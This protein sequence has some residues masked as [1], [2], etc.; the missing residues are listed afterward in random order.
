MGNS[1]PARERGSR[2]ARRRCRGCGSVTPT[3]F[4]LRTVD[5]AGNSVPFSER[6][7]AAARSPTLTSEAQRYLR[8]EPVPSPAVLRRHLDTEG[9]S[10]EHLAI[11]SNLDVSAEDYAVSAARSSRRSSDAGAAH[12]YAEDSQRHLAPPK[13]SE[14][15]AEQD[16]RLEAAFGG[17]A[18][19]MTAALRTALREEGTFLDEEIVDL[20]TGQKTI[21]QSPIALLPASATLPGGAGCR[22][23]AGRLR[24]PPGRRTVLLPYLP[25]PL[26]IGVSI[27]GYDFTGAEVFHER[28][29]VRR[30]TGRS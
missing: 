2:A 14:Q 18:A 29:N 3:A 22:T 6:E 15:M 8:F 1:V 20:A 5:L 24:L 30:R 16:G 23:G 12:A 21:A 7:L 10:L 4:E 25:D 11:R 19:A 27:T 9:E 17:T 26:A 13:A 28:A